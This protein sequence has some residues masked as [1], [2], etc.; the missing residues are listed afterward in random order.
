[1]GSSRTD[2]SRL[3]LSS[4]RTALSLSMVLLGE[5][6]VPVVRHDLAVYVVQQVHAHEVEPE[7]LYLL[8]RQVVALSLLRRARRSLRGLQREVRLDAVQDVLLRRL[9][10]LLERRVVR[11]VRRREGVE[12]RPV[13][14]VEEG[15]AFDVAGALAAEA[16]L[17]VCLQEAF[18]E[19]VE[20][21]RDAFFDSRLNWV[22]RAYGWAVAA[23]ERSGCCRGS[24][25]RTSR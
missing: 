14:S 12:V 1:M 17:G 18:D 3:A 25:Q 21:E 19:V 15:V 11:D 9:L 16:L 13:Y 6:R 2:C 7:A 20:L 22:N 23:C 4:A 24:R 10:E 8:G 5:G